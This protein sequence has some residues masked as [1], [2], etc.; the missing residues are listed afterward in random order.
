MN[1]FLMTK[2]VFFYF[3]DLSTPIFNQFIVAIIKK[4]YNSKNSLEIEDTTI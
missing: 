4:I 1:T 2:K 3:F